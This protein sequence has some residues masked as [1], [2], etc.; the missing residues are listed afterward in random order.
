MV[1]L[2]RSVRGLLLG[3]ALVC[4]CT[5]LALPAWAA[6]EGPRVTGTV[7]GDGAAGGTLTIEVDALQVGGWQGLD[8]IEVDLGVDGKVADR[9]VFDI[10]N[11]ILTI[12]T[13]DIVVGTGA[14]ASGEY[15]QV[16]GADV[17]VTTGGGHLML[18]LRATAL[19]EIPAAARF[20]LVATDDAGL[21]A[22][23]TRSVA[24]P[25]GGGGVSW[26][27]VATFVAIALFAGG[28]LGNM[29]ASR[30]RPPA[31]PSVYAAI[32]R[33]M[34]ADRPQEPSRP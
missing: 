28:F 27:Q 2:R 8:A 26:G 12:N 32:Q 3:G 18:R 6:G 9:L 7:S 25:T 13:Q 20:E 5:L 11:N 23:A 34:E 24:A 17:L 30:R 10:G 21:S 15:L 22:S 31:R 14:R 16:D 29:I 33:R 19:K 1:V 4:L